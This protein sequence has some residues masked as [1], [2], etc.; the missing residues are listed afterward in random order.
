MQADDILKAVHRE[1]QGDTSYP[2]SGDEDYSLRFAMIEDSIN[3]WATRGSEEN[4][5][6][7]ELFTT[8]ADSPDGDKTATTSVTDYDCPAKF[9]A[10]TS[11]VTIT[12]GTNTL[13]YYDVITPDRVVEY[14]KNHSGEYWVYQTGNEADGYTLHFNAPVAGT[15]NYNYYKTPAIPT[16]GTSKV[17]MKRPYFIV[18]DIVSRLF[19]LDGRND[20]VTFHEGKK[21]NL[22]DTMVIDNELVPFGNSNMLDDLQSNQGV[23]FG[24]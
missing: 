12:D 17:E 16:T 19:K 24:K 21:K 2:V 6:W 5:D 9:V 8:L 22:M 23:R 15:I 7:K 11:K 10:L 13:Q 18:H 20:L 14:Q 3:T 4:I 1:Y